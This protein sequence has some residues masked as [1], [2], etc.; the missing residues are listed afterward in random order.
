MRSKRNEV[1]KIHL[2]E[3]LAE[4]IIKMI[5]VHALSSSELLRF[6]A[7]EISLAR[8]NDGR[9]F[10]IEKIKRDVNIK[11]IIVRL[12]AQEK[13]GYTGMAKT[14]KVCLSE[15]FRQGIERIALLKKR[16]FRAAY[17]GYQYRAFVGG[18]SAQKYR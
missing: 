7:D 2:T 12:T 3:K 4:T 18:R 9:K 11:N 1:T 10:K 13:R 15:L 17:E 8:A 5:H 14:L 6:G 16:E